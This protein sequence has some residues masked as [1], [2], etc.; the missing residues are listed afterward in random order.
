MYRLVSTPPPDLH[1]L[2]G[3]E[4]RK[5]AAALFSCRGRA[6]AVPMGGEGTFLPALQQ[7]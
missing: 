1:G 3:L 6:V 4:G 5:A 2:G 7:E